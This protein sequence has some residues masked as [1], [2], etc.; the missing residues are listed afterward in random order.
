MGLTEGE[1]A[2]EFYS[3]SIDLIAE[4]PKGLPDAAMCP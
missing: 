1:P 2:L 3:A 4:G